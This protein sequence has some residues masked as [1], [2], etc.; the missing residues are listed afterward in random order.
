MAAVFFQLPRLPAFARHARSGN[1]RA[2]GVTNAVIFRIYGQTTG[3]FRWR[4]PHRASSGER[5]GKRIRRAWQLHFRPVP[6]RLLRREMKKA[7]LAKVE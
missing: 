5:P 1:E 3:D 2:A 4:S 7:S 6:Q